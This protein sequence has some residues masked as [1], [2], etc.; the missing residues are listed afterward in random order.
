MSHKFFDREPE[1]L[2]SKV[3]CPI[4]HQPTGPKSECY[5]LD[6]AQTLP[7]YKKNITG[8]GTGILPIMSDNC[9][10]RQNNL[11]KAEIN[12]PVS[13]PLVQELAKVSGVDAVVP[14]PQ[15]K[16]CFHVSVAKLFDEKTVKQEITR[17]YRQFI[18]EMSLQ[19]GPT[20]EPS[21]THTVGVRFP[22][23]KE[24]VCNSSLSSEE[25]EKQ[26]VW[27]HI[28]LEGIEGTSPI[29]EKETEL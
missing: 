1:L 2:W 10:F 12:Y 16:Y 26:L 23:G 6:A 8:K 5:N 19:E 28:L 7:E 15:T 22:N 17:R 18:K 14:L 24:F 3:M 27:I 9:T 21:Q 20:H 13:R 29:S 11:W 4:C 25:K